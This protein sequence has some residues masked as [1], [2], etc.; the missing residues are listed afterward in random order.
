M[1]DSLPLNLLVETNIQVV[2][3]RLPRIF[4]VIH[5]DHIILEDPVLAIW[6]LLF[7]FETH[8]TKN[9]LNRKMN[10]TTIR[11]AAEDV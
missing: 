5:T 6:I 1:N 4:F 8:H 9:Y 10:F 3:H 2:C 7:L 11:N